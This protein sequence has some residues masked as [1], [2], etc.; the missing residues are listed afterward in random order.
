MFG[1]GLALPAAVSLVRDFEARQR[2]VRRHAAQLQGVDRE[3][4][5]RWGGRAPQVCVCV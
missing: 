1:L 4:W 5:L 3:R 2:F